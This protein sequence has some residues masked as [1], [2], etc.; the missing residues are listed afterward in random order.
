MTQIYS[1]THII[2]IDG[3]Y[4]GVVVEELD[5][6]A[7]PRLRFVACDARFMLLDGSRFRTLASAQQAARTLARVVAG[8]V[9]TPTLREPRLSVPANDSGTAGRLHGSL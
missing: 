7:M 2:A 1:T 8:D 4:A 5:Q 6:K 9:S 3:Y